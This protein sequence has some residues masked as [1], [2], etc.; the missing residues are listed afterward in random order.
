VIGNHHA[1]SRKLVLEHMYLMEE[2]AAH[3]LSKALADGAKNEG[4][5]NLAESTLELK[6]HTFLAGEGVEG[7][8]NGSIVFVGNERLFRRL[9][10]FDSLPLS[11]KE[12]VQKWESMGATIGFM[13][14]GDHGI[15]CSY[16]AADAVR[17]EAKEVLADLHSMGINITMLTGDNRKTAL[18]IGTSIGLTEDTIVSEL[19][20]EEK[21]AIVSET[22]EIV[23]MCGDG[24]NDAPALAAANVGVAMGHG[25]ALAMETADVALLDSSLTKLAYG[26]KMGRKVRNKIIQNVTFS[27]AVK[28]IIIVFTLLHKVTLSIAIAVDLGGMLAVTLNGMSLLSFTK[29][30]E[31]K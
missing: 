18:A 28:V 31:K 17:P 2:R 20:P 26:V 6:D 23:L 11:E 10:M 14:I 24:V 22:K 30:K 15:V 4:I 7:V 21:L 27:I 13:S 5:I 12:K 8:I 29:K 9:G 19:L 25:A 16:C 3:P 1:Y